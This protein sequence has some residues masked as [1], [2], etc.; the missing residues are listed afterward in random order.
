MVIL[1][2][3]APMKERGYRMPRTRR[4]IEDFVA[5][6]GHTKESRNY[7]ISDTAFFTF[8]TAAVREGFGGNIGS[9]MEH[10]ARELS[11]K[12]LTK[13]DREQVKK[14]ADQETGKRRERRIA[15]ANL[16]ESA[17]EGT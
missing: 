2:Q 16:A 14:N 12:V 10:L 6:G 17:E 5:E 9:Y 3:Q 13:A 1:W 8:K 7:L 4:T 11:E 15:K